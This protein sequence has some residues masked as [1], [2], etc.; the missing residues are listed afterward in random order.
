MW[1]RRR[2]L[3]AGACAGGLGI[4][5]YTWRIEPHWIELTRRSLPIENLPEELKGA[6]LAHLSDLHV[7]SSVDSTYLI[8]V[9]QKVRRIEPD[10]VAFTG[11]FVSYTDVERFDELAR[12]LE[13]WPHGRYA[14][15]AA[16]GNHDY[17]W[18]WRQL[19]VAA[20][21]ARRAR[22]AGITVLR[23]TA[24]TIAGLQ[25]AGLE[26]YW[27]PSFDPPTA[28]SELDPNRAA[29]V[30]CHNPDVA[31]R[32]VWGDYRGWILS[33]HTHGGQC[34]PPF[35]PPPILPVVNKRYTEGELALTGG[36]RLYISLGIGYL[37]RVRF[38]VRPEVAIF[39]LTAA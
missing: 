11:D 34:K 23:N 37:L 10:I 18:N 36:R 25:I 4:I 13:H 22:D 21:V 27:A 30:L 33:G 6:T 5:A 9:L 8:D 29:L 19:E 17:G 26:D 15:V 24:R 16:L 1:T 35:I 32:P 14:T 20:A 2:F 12:V 31:D 38:N 39:T 28:L 7:G 3:Q